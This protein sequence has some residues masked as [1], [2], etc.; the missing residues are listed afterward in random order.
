MALGATTFGIPLRGCDEQTAL[1]LV[2]RY[3]DAGGNLVDTASGY[4]ASEEICG[5]AVRGRRDEVVLATKFGMAVGRGPY[6]RGAGRKYNKEIC[7]TSL[8]GLRTDRFDLYWRQADA[9]ATTPLEETLAASHF[10]K[11]W[12]WS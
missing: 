6:A 11:T 1:Q 4:L 10:G 3:L 5:R 12:F 9:V 8:R 7:E 2:Y